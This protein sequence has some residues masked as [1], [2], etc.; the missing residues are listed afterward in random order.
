MKTNI[1]FS[2]SLIQT[3]T[4]VT[5]TDASGETLTMM[6]FD[7]FK[8]SLFGQTPDYI[9]KVYENLPNFKFR[10]DDI[11]IASYPKAGKTFVSYTIWF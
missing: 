2:V 5:V 10:E 6:D 3:M 9:R 11:F 4:E 8:M 1:L 7:G